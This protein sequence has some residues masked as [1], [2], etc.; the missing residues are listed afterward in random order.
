MHQNNLQA[1]L[2]L[3]LIVFIWGFTGIIGALVS[4]EAAVMVWWRMAIASA[5]LYVYALIS[6]QK[7]KLNKRD[8]WGLLGT[9]IIIAAH[10]VTF[11]GSIKASN[12]SVALACISSGALF[13]S[14]L[15]PLIFKRSIKKSEI[16]LG[17]VSICGL[18]LIFGSEMRYIEGLLLGL[19]SSFLSVLFAVIN[20]LYTKRIAATTISV[21]ELLGGFIGLSLFLALND[22][23]DPGF[24]A[25]S[26]TDFGWIV[27]LATVCTAF[28]F[29]VSVHVMRVLSPFTVV[30]TINLEPIYGILLA[31][32]VFGEKEQMSPPFYVGTLLIIGAIL[33]N[34][35]N[36]RLSLH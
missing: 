14:F 29:V 11:F 32:L 2:K 20:G 17:I 8:V 31:F 1:Q 7:L 19:V 15:E 34:A 26:A 5:V 22:N 36:K 35:I 28:A 3:H 27:V 21:Y 13:A 24:L 10:W 30:L 6:K 33:M 18:S 25:L 12:V 16:V 23:L 4:V 9:G